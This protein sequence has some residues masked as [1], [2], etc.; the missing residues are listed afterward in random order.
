MIRII[1]GS[2]IFNTNLGSGSGTG[3]GNLFVKKIV[4]KNL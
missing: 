3:S 1:A 4:F 2:G